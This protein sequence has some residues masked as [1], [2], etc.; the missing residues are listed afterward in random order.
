[1]IKTPVFHCREYGFDPG[2]GIKVPE[3]SWQKKKTKDKTSNILTNSK[4]IILM[5]HIKKKL[6]K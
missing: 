3:A 6:K 2:W 5:V 1:M 4:K